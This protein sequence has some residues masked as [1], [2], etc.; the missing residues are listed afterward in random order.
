MDAHSDAVVL[1]NYF[2]CWVVILQLCTLWRTNRLFRI[3][4]TLENAII[5]LREEIDPLRE[6]LDLLRNDVD[7]VFGRK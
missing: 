4:D 1:L 3:M 6:D 7:D 5:D 2:L